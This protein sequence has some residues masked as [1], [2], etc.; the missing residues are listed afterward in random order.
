M[1]VSST[2]SSSSGFSESEEENLFSDETLHSENDMTEGASEEE[3]ETSFRK[4]SYMASGKNSSPELLDI[5][6]TLKY[7]IK[8]LIQDKDSLVE[9]IKTIRSQHAKEIVELRGDIKKKRSKLKKTRAK[10]IKVETSVSLRGGTED[11]REQIHLHQETIK[12]REATIQDLLT[13]RMFLRSS[14]EWIKQSVSDTFPRYNSLLYSATFSNFAMLTTE[15]FLDFLIEDSYSDDRYEH[16]SES[17]SYDPPP[18]VFWIPYLMWFIFGCLGWL[19][20]AYVSKHNTLG[21]KLETVRSATFGEV[22]VENMREAIEGVDDGSINQVLK[23]STEMGRTKRLGS[24][25]V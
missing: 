9:H 19:L 14:I 10:L 23:R 20:D 21:K 11:L 6:D 3:I 16:S 12:Q 15:A 4:L 2:Y 25:Y 1:D 5:T 24:V 17:G 18:K 8:T 7:Q 13:L 22:P